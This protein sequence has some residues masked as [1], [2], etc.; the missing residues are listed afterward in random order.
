MGLPGVREWYEYVEGTEVQ[1]GT[2]LK[3]GPFAW[4]AVATTCLETMISVKFGHGLYPN[5]CPRN[6]GLAWGISGGLSLG[7]FLLW[8]AVHELTQS[9]RR[10]LEGRTAAVGGKRCPD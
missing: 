10:V 3:L 1:G 7:A 8:V 4:T 9:R 6:V 2:S 5:Q